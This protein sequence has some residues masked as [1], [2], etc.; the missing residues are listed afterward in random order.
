MCE[1]AVSYMFIASRVYKL[2]WSEVSLP[3]WSLLGDFLQTDTCSL[4]GNHFQ[5]FG[6]Q[7]LT[8]NCIGNA[9]VTNSG[10]ESK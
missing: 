7:S 4:A 5:N 3:L 6:H 9:L 10:P 2:K 8:L 1:N